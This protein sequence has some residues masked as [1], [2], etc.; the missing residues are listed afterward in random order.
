MNTFRNF[1]ISTKIIISLLFLFSFFLGVTTFLSLRISN[2]S[3]TKERVESSE[4]ATIRVADIVEAYIGSIQEKM[5]LIGQLPYAKA[6][7]QRNGNRLLA[8]TERVHFTEE[9]QATLSRCIEC[10]E[11]FFITRD[12]KIIEMFD[13]TG[14]VRTIPEGLEAEVGQHMSN[15]TVIYLRLSAEEDSVDIVLITPLKN[16]SLNIIGYVGAIIDPSVLFIHLQTPNEQQIFRL[17]DRKG[18]YIYHEDAEKNFSNPELL[19]HGFS[20]KEDFPDIAQD[21]LLGTSIA[22]AHN[23]E[24]ITSAPAFFNSTESEDFWIVQGVIRNQDALEPII[25]LRNIFI[26]ISLGAMALL[27]ATMVFLLHNLTDP[28][29]DI[30]SVAKQIT[31]GKYDKR[32]RI[33]SGDEIGQLGIQFNAMAAALTKKNKELA[34]KVQEKTDELNE[35]IHRA[36][37]QNEKLERVKSA[38]I[39]LLED[40]EESKHSIE[41]EKAQDEAILESIGEGL[42]AIGPDYRIR[43][44]NEQARQLLGL[45]TKDVT[46][47]L[48]TDLIKIQN[49][50]QENLSLEHWPFYKALKEN[51]KVFSSQYN[52]VRPNGTAFPAAMTS[53]PILQGDAKQGVITVFRDISKEKEIEKA[54]SEFVSMASHQLRT[55]L[56]AINWYA[57]MLMDEDAGKINEEQKAYLN[58]IKSGNQR[59]I[60]LV[61]GLLDVSRI[62]LGTFTI[63]PV[64]T[65]IRNIADSVIAE[66]EPL[67]SEKELHVIK[68]YDSRV[69]E[70]NL[71]PNLTRIILQNLLSN[72]TKF[73]GKKGKIGAKITNLDK[74][75]LI[76]ISDTGMGIPKKQQGEIFTKLFRADNVKDIQGT[77]LGLYI[78]R[79]ILKQAGGKI[80]FESKEGKGTT[81][82]LEIPHEGMKAKQGSRRL[83]E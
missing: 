66:L 41:Q 75:V 72:A 15:E 14:E 79:S 5:H 37:A 17:V 78:I 50:K 48:W 18:Y 29:R 9:I 57:E 80:W 22:E 20:I 11:V 74:S 46:G 6:I 53:A 42:V 82:F 58:E 30:L 31:D 21:I 16:E 19:R 3:I 49:G 59:M 38:M 70:V 67:I 54:K 24:I 40:V 73:T 39:N 23:N 47:L 12:R 13:A 65:D 35:R 81:F 26:I 7:I 27:L 45:G 4:L 68:E 8:N 55:P 44:M 10:K 56:S 62:E 32:V 60:S 64:P 77:G 83:S 33:K 36:D 52:I 34:D 2:D 43:L 28:I 69:P 1:N 63:E 51:K 71:D 25:N 61:N 76:E